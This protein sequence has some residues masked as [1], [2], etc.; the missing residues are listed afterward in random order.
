MGE[1]HTSPDRAPLS[2][3]RIEHQGTRFLGRAVPLPIIATCGYVCLAAPDPWLPALLALVFFVG[4]MALRQYIWRAMKAGRQPSPYVAHIRGLISI[5]FIPL[6]VFSVGPIPGGWVPAV[7]PLLL[8]PFVLALAPALGASLALLVLVAL[9][10]YLIDVPLDEVVVE[11]LVMGTITFHAIPIAHAMRR[12]LGTL[13]G[14]QGEL[15]R[16]IGRAE[17]ASRAKGSFLAQM[18]HEIRTP[19]NG[20]IGSLDLLSRA[21]DDEGAL[22]EAARTSADGLLDLVDDILDLS[23]VEAG[24]MQPDLRPTHAPTLL[25]QVGNAFGAMAAERGLELRLEGADDVPPWAS[26]DP[27]RLRQVVFNLVSNAIKFTEKGWVTVRLESAADTLKVTVI[28]T[29][30]GMTPDVLDRV[31]DPFEQASPGHKGTGLGLSLVIRLTE[32]LGGHLDA[33]SVP[34]EGSRFEVNVPWRPCEPPARATAGLPVIESEGMRVLVVEDNPINQRVVRAM[35]DRLDCVSE[36]AENA[37]QAVEMAD[38]DFDL[39]LMDLHLPDHDGF[40]A[41]RRIRSMGIRTPIWALTAGA[42]LEHR[43]RAAEAG[44]NGFLTKP[45]RF[46]QLAETLHH[47]QLG[48]DAS[49]PPLEQSPGEP[50]AREA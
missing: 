35:L 37:N 1:G 43:A 21:P 48:D 5:V 50:A 9:C 44:M 45:L 29:G 46:D 23:K 4:N 38:G 10:R 25:T 30:R 42:L 6:L 27:V 13:S 20:I 26:C 11:L 19:L 40:N 22:L 32:L 3:E 8:L 47:V 33:N 36:L 39:I 15:R 17:A 18:S 14:L 12:Y 49:L 16:Q 7:P 28:D 34:G 31:F 24:H 2:G 41:T